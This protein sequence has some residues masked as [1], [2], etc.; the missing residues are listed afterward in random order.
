MDTQTIG[1]IVTPGLMIKRR[2]YPFSPRRK[3]N[4]RSIKPL[5]AF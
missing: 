5:G 2:A 1:R 4:L 3:K